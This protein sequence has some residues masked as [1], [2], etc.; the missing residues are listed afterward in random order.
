[1]RGLRVN[2]MTPLLLFLTECSVGSGIRLLVLSNEYIGSL[3]QLDIMLSVSHS[4]VGTGQSG[5]VLIDSPPGVLCSSWTGC[6]GLAA[7]LVVTFRHH[8]PSIT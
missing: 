3:R 8:Y 2:V 5:S 4:T 7:F 1:M 6:V